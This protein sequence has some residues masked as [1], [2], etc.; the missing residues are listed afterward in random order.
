MTEA[1]ALP[2]L[3]E[4]DNPSARS[5]TLT[6]LLARP[7]DAPEVMA[8]QAAIPGWGPARAILDAQWPAGYWMHPGVGYSPKYKATIWQVIFLA[9]LGAP[10]VEAI[11][12]ACTYVLDHAL[13]PDG[14]FTADKTTKGAIL[15]LGG[16]LLRAMVQ[17]GCPDPRIEQS[18]EVLATTAVR[19][20]FRCR[21]NASPRAAQH[22]DG[23]P[24]AWGAV[25]VLGA[26]AQV[27]AE[28]RSAAV[29]AA[30]EAGIAFL[31]SGDPATGDYPAA[32]RPSALWQKLSFPLGY[33][34]DQL[35]ALEVLSAVPSAAGK[36]GVGHD[37][38]LTSVIEA[39]LSK[40]DESGRWALEHTLANT[41][42]RF[43]TVGRPNKWV[44]IRALRVLNRC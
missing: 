39:V 38:R 22:R 30:I 20:G 9:Q 6:G 1:N 14:R 40:Q 32:T 3:L 19:D 12:R 24:C 44:T 18:L 42:A 36:P 29:Q 2:W 16:N 4:A 35:E 28:Q 8:A 13:L 31:L 26:L 25:K 33:A 10:R 5:L 17:L 7:A 23:L 15:C 27:P 41:W 43:G 21:C 34:S 11:D 37:P